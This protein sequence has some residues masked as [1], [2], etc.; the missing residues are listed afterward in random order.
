MKK[1]TG[2]TLIEI[3][4]ALLIGLVIVVA[5]I[6]I[7]IS[8]IKGSKDVINSARLNHDLESVMSLMVNDIRRAGYWG[9]AVV[10]ADSSTNPFTIGTAN[11]QI[12]TAACILYSY[13]ADGDR[14]PDNSEYYGFKLQSGA[15]KIRSADT[16]ETTVD[17]TGTGWS[18]LTVEESVN[19]TALTFTTAYRCLDASAD[20]PAS[21]IWPCAI[22]V[23]AGT[24]PGHKLVES[25]Q[26]NIV[27]TGQLLNDTTVT[28]TLTGIVKVRNDRIC[29]QGSNC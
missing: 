23:P 19:I 20:P 26:L 21:F 14:S 28:K 2:Y 6:T 15:V 1:Q 11:I 12:P 22:A 27:L 18:T 8:T 17:C 9:G 7:Y 29:I 24:L 5:T 13:D 10:G 25:R 3:M 4:V 16:A